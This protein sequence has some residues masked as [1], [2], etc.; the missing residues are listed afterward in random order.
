MKFKKFLLIVIIVLALGILEVTGIQIYQERVKT[1]NKY[2]E[3]AIADQEE[4]KAQRELERQ[5]NF[6][7][8]LEKG[9]DAKIL[10]VGNSMG[11]SE[12]SSSNGEWIDIG[13]LKIR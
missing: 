12:E 3:L 11:L 1:E 13:R 10:V 2:K 5:S 6:Y 9:F 4:R 7:E 8:K